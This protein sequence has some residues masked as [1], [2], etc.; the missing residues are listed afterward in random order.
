MWCTSQMGLRRENVWSGQDFNRFDMTFTFDKGW[1]KVCPLTKST[2]W[3]KY[4]IPYHWPYQPN[5]R[6]NIWSIQ[7]FYTKVYSHLLNLQPWNLIQDYCTSFSKGT[8][9]VKHKPDW[10][11]EGKNE[12]VKT[13]K[14][15]DHLIFNQASLN[16]WPRPI[17]KVCFCCGTAK[18]TQLD[19][20]FGTY[21]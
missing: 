11:K 12:G 6:D 3:V 10:E 16:G 8:L 19:H 14:F 7:G 5:R 15:N 4:L 20:S 1:F 13:N 17:W 18:V 2:A 21:Q 9:W